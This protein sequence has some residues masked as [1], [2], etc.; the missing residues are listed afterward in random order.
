MCR[1]QYSACQLVTIG[2]MLFINLQIYYSVSVVDTSMLHVMAVGLEV[3]L[4]IPCNVGSFESSAAHSCS[5][6]G[7]TGS[8]LKGILYRT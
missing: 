6:F 2:V 1:Q 3:T 8:I 5:E 4:F 7:K